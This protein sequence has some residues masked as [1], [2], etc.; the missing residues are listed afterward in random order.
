M[1]A[2]I[3]N[4]RRNRSGTPGKDIPEQGALNQSWVLRMFLYCLGIYAITQLKQ[5]APKNPCEQDFTVKA[6]N[7]PNPTFLALASSDTFTDLAL[8]GQAMLYDALRADVTLIG[9]DADEDTRAADCIVSMWQAER[10]PDSRWEVIQ[11]RPGAFMGRR[12]NQSSPFVDVGIEYTPYYSTSIEASFQEQLKEKECLRALLISLI[13]EGHID[14]TGPALALLENYL[15][16][17]IQHPIENPMEKFKQEMHR[18]ISEASN[19]EEAFDAIVSRLGQA[20][21]IKEF[22]GQLRRKPENVCYAID[23]AR[24]K[25]KANRIAPTGHCPQR[26]FVIADANLLR[27]GKG[28]PVDSVVS[29]ADDGVSVS[30]LLPK[31]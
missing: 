19:P 13:V 5:A 28:S 4:A 8:Q 27:Y 6:A 23:V 16:C 26:F 30:V 2:S 24:E 18:M 31:K 3:R 25:A 7:I 17:V 1:P 29:R 20:M 15:F 9:K 11:H 14:S 21:Q 22:G 12:D 10:C